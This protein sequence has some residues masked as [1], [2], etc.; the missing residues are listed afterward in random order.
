MSLILLKTDIVS[1]PTWHLYLANASQMGNMFL[2]SDP[3][4]AQELEGKPANRL[5]T[6]EGIQKENFLSDESKKQRASDSERLK[7][8]SVK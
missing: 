2:T 5:M 3:S 4:A 8:M 6:W 1:L 7:R